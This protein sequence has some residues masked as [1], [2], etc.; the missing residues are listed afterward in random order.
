MA[1][2]VLAGGV[3]AIAAYEGA[4]GAHSFLWRASFLG[5]GILEAPIVEEL[6]FRGAIQTSLN[7]TGLGSRWVWKLKM[8]TIVAAIAFGCTHFL[9]LVV[10]VP[11]TRT[12]FEVLSAI[13]AGLLFGYCYQRTDNIWYG[14]Y[15]HALGNLAG[16]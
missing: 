5:G 10:G 4:F 12:L 11:I 14:V 15:L 3:I 7:Q 6:V 8:G 2:V 16:A 13:P 9:L 1:W